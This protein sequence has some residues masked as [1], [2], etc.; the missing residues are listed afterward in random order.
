MGFWIS[1]RISIA[2]SKS[3][4]RRFTAA[5]LKH[6]RHLSAI[7]IIQH[8]QLAHI[9]NTN[10]RRFHKKKKKT[11]QIAMTWLMVNRNQFKTVIVFALTVHEI[12][13]KILNNKRIV[14]FRG[15]YSRNASV[16]SM[17]NH[18]IFKIH[19]T[20]WFK[21]VWNSIGLLWGEFSNPLNHQL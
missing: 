18:S 7:K 1:N 19:L 20:I 4:V 21:T 6:R 12:G 5:I 15:K 8:F 2:L 10:V 14:W 16:F 11:A 13:V 9:I 17:K 3:Q